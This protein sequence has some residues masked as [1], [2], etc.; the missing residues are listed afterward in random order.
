MT[1]WLRCFLSLSN[2]AAQDMKLVNQCTTILKSVVCLHTYNSLC[3]VTLELPRW[4]SRFNCI[5]MAF[6]CQLFSFT[7]RDFSPQIFSGWHFAEYFES[8]QIPQRGAAEP[9]CMEGLG[10]LIQKEAQSVWATCRGR[11]YAGSKSPPLHCPG[12]S[13]QW[14]K[15]RLQVYFVFASLISPALIE[16]RIR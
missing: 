13:F 15:K 11:R 1:A 5:P 2:V 9:F 16:C 10:L 12:K 4:L 14:E 6:C 8:C 3:A 7:A